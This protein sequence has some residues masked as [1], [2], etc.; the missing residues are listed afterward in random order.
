M[1][2]YKLILVS[3]VLSGCGALVKS[4]KHD[5]VVSGEAI[6]TQKITVDFSICD[7]F[8]GEEKLECIRILLDAIAKEEKKEE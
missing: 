7:Q 1:A 3:F 4:S 5:V 2:V 6:I 8:Y